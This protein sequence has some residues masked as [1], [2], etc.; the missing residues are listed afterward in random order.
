[1][2]AGAHGLDPGGQTLSAWS[3]DCR[4][5][6]SS[7]HEVAGEDAVN[8]RAPGRERGIERVVP[9]NRFHSGSQSDE[10]RDGGGNEQRVGIQLDDRLVALQRP[11]C[12]TPGGAFDTR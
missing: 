9:S 4:I 11:D 3:P 6:G 12:D 5:A 1:M 8:E 10:F 2:T 7:R